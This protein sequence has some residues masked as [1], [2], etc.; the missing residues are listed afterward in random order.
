MN[1]LNDAY[2]M[3]LALKEANTALQDDEVPIGAVIVCNNKIIAK[4]YN[5]TERLK[6]V[7][8][9]AEMIAIT[10]AANYLGAKFLEDCTLYVTV[11][12]CPM[13][14]AALRWARI[15]K[16]IYGAHDPKAGYTLFGP[17]LFHPKTE[18]QHGVLEHE[19]GTLMTDFF[20]GKR[21]K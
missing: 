3:R 16:V 19:C 8:A 9:H 15:S 17:K 7:T 10:A 1:L 13:C 21:G 20:R 18:I 14:A 2:W 5:Q 12:P 6:D 11:E 4:G